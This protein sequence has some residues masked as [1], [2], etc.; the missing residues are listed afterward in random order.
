MKLFKKIIMITFKIVKTLYEIKFEVHKKNVK[1]IQKHGI[2]KVL[3]R[4]N[5]VIYKLLASEF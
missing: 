4:K 5:L 1:I 3:S 2:Y